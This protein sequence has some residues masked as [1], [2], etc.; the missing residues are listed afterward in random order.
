M[1][2]LDILY[3]ISEMAILY[4]QYTNIRY[5]GKKL[6]KHIEIINVKQTRDQ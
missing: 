1:I 6:F 3:I 5:R 2:Q 4:M